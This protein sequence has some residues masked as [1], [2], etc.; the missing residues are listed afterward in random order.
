MAC[1]SV[2]QGGDIMA[3]KP[4]KV[5]QLNKYIGRVMQTDPILG[6]VSVTGEISNLKYHSSG[7]VYFTLKDDSS[8][9]NCFMPAGAA[10]SMRFQLADGMEVVTAGYISV[11]EK[12]GYYSLNI[13]DVQVSGEGGLALAYKAMY[14]R[15]LKEGLFDASHKKQL[16]P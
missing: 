11:Y 16:Q 12:G 8:K 7:H 1:R 3:L 14:E 6:N 4:I 10:R 15:L 9:V 13:R 5:S 2:S